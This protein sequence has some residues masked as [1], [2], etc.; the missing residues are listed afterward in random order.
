MP[1]PCPGGFPDLAEAHANLGL[2]LQLL[3][4]PRAE[5]S[6]ERALAA[7]PDLPGVATNLGILRSEL[8]AKQ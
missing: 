2:T 8:P 1:D 7:C 3:K 6:Y 4:D 5:Q